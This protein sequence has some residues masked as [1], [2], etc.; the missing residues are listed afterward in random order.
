MFSML[1]VLAM[2]PLESLVPPKKQQRIRAAAGDS[3]GFSSRGRVELGDAALCG[4]T[5]KKLL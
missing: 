2:T 4:C 5:K 1:R 3:G